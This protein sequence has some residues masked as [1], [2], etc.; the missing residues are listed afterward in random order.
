MSRYDLVASALSIS[1]GTSS[2]DW[3]DYAACDPADADLFFPEPPSGIPHDV[4]IAAAKRICNRCLVQAPC[5]AYAL[6]N[7]INDGVWGGLD[8]D[9][10]RALVRRM[11][12]EDAA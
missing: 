2:G 6:G 8:E 4:D 3:R 10:R 12:R 7:R 5:L 9:E 11:A 1:D